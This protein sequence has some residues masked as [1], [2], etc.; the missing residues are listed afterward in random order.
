MLGDVVVVISVVCVAV[1]TE[2]VEIIFEFLDSGVGILM[3]L[4][5]H[6]SQIHRTSDDEVVV[7]QTKSQHVNWFAKFLGE[8]AADESSHEFL[9]FF[10][11]RLIDL[12]FE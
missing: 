4:V 8:R 2:E 7:S 12:H 5:L 9:E 10:E 11:H 3:E 1:L 6:C